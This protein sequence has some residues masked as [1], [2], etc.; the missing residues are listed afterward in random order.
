MYIGPGSPGS[1]PRQLTREI[2]ERVARDWP[3]LLLEGLL[4]IVSGVLIF[5]ID[6]SVR[7]LS[8][9]IGA[10]FIM[11]GFSTALVRGLDRTAQTTNVVSGLLSVAAGVAIIVW[12]RPGVTAVAVF[13]GAW[14]ILMGTV[15]ISGAFAGRDII[16][17]WWLWLILG[18]LEVP[19]GVLA[20]ADPGGT[21]A[22]MVTVAGIW[23]VAIGVTYVV[24][25]FQLK[26]LPHRLE[27]LELTPEG[28]GDSAKSKPHAGRRSPS[29]TSPQ[30]T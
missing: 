13:L 25:S 19:L 8:I 20:L 5:S 30:A 14:L 24:M 4:L 15:T 3:A 17:D 11:H 7:S 28:S 27:E 22:A 2:A 6:W 1:F 29:T 18:L 16:P 9:F 10:L 21:L 26:R 12:P 23:A